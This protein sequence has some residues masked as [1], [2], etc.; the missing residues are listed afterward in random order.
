MGEWLV[1][2]VSRVRMNGHR[3]ESSRQRPMECRQPVRW[4]ASLLFNV[5]EGI[6]VGYVSYYL[7]F[8][9]LELAASVRVGNINS[10]AIEEF[11]LDLG[12]KP[13]VRDYNGLK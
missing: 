2:V 9:R 3:H 5:L 12:R 13:T 1:T 7:R 11:P 10:Q 4:T 6:P 8:E